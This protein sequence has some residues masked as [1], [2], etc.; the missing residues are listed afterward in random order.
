MELKKSF[1]TALK[2]PN[3]FCHGGALHDSLWRSCCTPAQCACTRESF[4][5]CNRD[6][7]RFVHPGSD[8]IIGLT[9]QSALA[10]FVFEYGAADSAAET[11]RQDMTCQK[12][13]PRVD[14]TSSGVAFQHASVRRKVQR[15]PGTSSRRHAGR[16]GGR[17]TR[18]IIAWA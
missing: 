6:L 16:R 14:Q 9:P 3:R 7:R 5:W 13:R 10:G 15:S 12:H 1:Q 4:R 17:A 8:P 11:A 2:T 18:K